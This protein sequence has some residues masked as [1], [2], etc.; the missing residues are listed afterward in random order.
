MFHFSFL[1]CI[2]G[3]STNPILIPPC[4]LFNSCILL[5]LLNFEMPGYCPEKFRFLIHYPN[6]SNIFLGFLKSC[7]VVL[8][9]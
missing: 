8:S 9:L 1:K 7:A 3:F 5:L 2:C 4:Q 6:N